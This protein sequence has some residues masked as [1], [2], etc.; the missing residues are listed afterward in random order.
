MGTKRACY[1]RAVPTNRGREEATSSEQKKE[2]KN[3]TV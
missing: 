1:L 3:G 2:E